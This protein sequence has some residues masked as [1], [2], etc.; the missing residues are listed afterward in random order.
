MRGRA[1][2]QATSLSTEHPVTNCF[3]APVIQHPLEV[4][5]LARGAKLEPL[6]C[7]LQ[8]GLRFFQHPLPANPLA[9]L[10]ARCLY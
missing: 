4:C 2:G 9:S 6:S 7:P 3:T 10:A 8:A 1:S 5:P